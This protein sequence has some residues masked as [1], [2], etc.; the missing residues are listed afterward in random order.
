MYLIE[1]LAA[2][3]DFA[4]IVLWTKTAA[5]FYERLG[6]EVS[7][8]AVAWRVDVR[9]IEAVL[10]AKLG[11]D[12]GTVWLRKRI[13]SRSTR[14]RIVVDVRAALGSERAVVAVEACAW[15]RQVGPSC[16]LG[17]LRAAADALGAT[18][19]DDIDLLARARARGLTRHGEFFDAAGLAF[20]AND[21][22]LEATLLDDADWPDI[23]RRSLRDRHLPIFAYD[24]RD[25]ATHAPVCRGGLGAHYALALG[26]TAN[27]NLLVLHGLSCRPLLAPLAHF[28]RSNR[29]LHD[30]PAEGDWLL[31]PDGRPRLKNR[32]VVIKRRGV[33][34]DQNAGPQ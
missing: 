11:A 17:A 6:Y 34:E 25:D 3:R 9:G 30:A 18:A 10:A 32:I 7:Q 19:V 29:Q 28:V 15:E 21:V 26:L 12:V 23:L 20:L 8:T 1:R 31:P 4:S 22:G 33:D 24:R 13:Q 5:G 2:E 16:G 27:D 14:T